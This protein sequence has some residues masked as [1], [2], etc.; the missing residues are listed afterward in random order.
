MRTISRYIGSSI[1]TTFILSLIV[2]VFVLSLGVVFKIT[3]LIAKGVP[4]GPTLMV[5]VYSMPASSMFAVPLS[6][7]ISVLLIF[8]RLSSDGEITAMRACGVSPAQIAT[9]PLLFAALMTAICL[10]INSEIVPW[11]H[12]AQRRVLSSLRGAAAS[13]SLLSEGQ[14]TQVMPNLALYVGRREGEVL[15]DVIVY[16]QR[17]EG[18]K[19]EIRAKSG[20]ITKDDTTKDLLFNLQDVRIDPF[21]DSRPG[22]GF[23]SRWIVSIPLSQLH[24][25]YRKKKSDMTFPELLTAIGNI[26][27]MY[28]SLPPEELPKHRMEMKVELNERVALAFSCFAFV[29]LGIPLGIKTHR[30]ESSIGIAISLL[31]IFGVYIFMLLANALAKRPECHPDLIVWTPIAAAVGLGI[32]LIRR[33]G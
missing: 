21:S 27:G 1:L 19:R 12:Y 8:G 3:D 7:V 32:Y 15:H 28:P 30:R 4:L 16:D 26:A 24:H 31:L 20:T 6:A 2:L 10:H 22:S 17:K 9:V 13:L 23:S 11:G 33:T 14:F 18:M 29:M 25:A 5:F